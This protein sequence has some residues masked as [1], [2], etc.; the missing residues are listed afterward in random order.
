MGPFSICGYVKF[1][2]NVRR[3]YKVRVLRHFFVWKQIKTPREDINS[4]QEQVSR[5]WHPNKYNVKAGDIWFIRV[6]YLLTACWHFG[7]KLRK[8]FNPTNY[9]ML[10]MQCGMYC[11]V[12]QRDR[13]RIHNDVIKWKHFPRYWSFVRGIHWSRWIPRTKTSDA[14]LWCFLWSAPE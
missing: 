10:W 1:F 4:G 5:V 7:R 9:A 6:P 12:L 11:G 2:T 3:R 14:E 13:S 8:I